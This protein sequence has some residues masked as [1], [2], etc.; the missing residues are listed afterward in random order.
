MR[1]PP[2][3][4]TVE[5]L[6][7]F[8]VI[9]LDKP[10]GPSSHQVS[11]WIRDLADRDSAAHAGTLDPKVTGCLPTLLD[12]ATRCAPALQGAD[13]TYTAV[14]ELHSEPSDDVT[15]TLEEFEGAIYQR[16]PRKSAVRRRLRTRKIH[17]LKMLER[18]QR[19]ALLKIRCEAGT[20]IRK[21]CHDLG[22]VLGTGANMGDLRRVQTGPFDDA[23]LVTLHDLVDALVE[24][25]EGD[26]ERFIR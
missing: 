16:P 24:W 15:P 17:E 13:K 23:N 25:R 4:R 6:L 5:E 20:Y 26:D 10:P 3:D 18:D 19:R 9:N 2:D 8:G 1:P 7:E 14:L 22:L 12:K 11:A 21:L